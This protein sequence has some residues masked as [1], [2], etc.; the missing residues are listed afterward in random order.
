MIPT[1]R[2][3]IWSM[4]QTL[5]DERSQLEVFDQEAEVFTWDAHNGRVF[6]LRRRKGDNVLLCISNFSDNPE[7]V[8]FAYF[9]GTYTDCFTG[10]K[11]EPGTGFV[12]QPLECLWLEN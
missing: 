8:R 9:V 10:R 5:R 11:V 3:K 6:A 7:P 4:F 1:Q 2:G 12:L